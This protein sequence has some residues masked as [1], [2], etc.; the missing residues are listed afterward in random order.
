MY[1]KSVAIVAIDNEF[2]HLPLN[3]RLDQNQLGDRRETGTAAVFLDRDGVVVED[4]HFIK[5][6]SEVRLLP[7]AA[8]ALARLRSKFFII[9]VTNQS[10]VAR[11]YFSETDLAEIHME[12]VDQLGGRGDAI[13][14]FY[15]CPHLPGAQITDYDVECACRK[16]A[17]GM[18][19]QAE[20]HW[21][22]D[23]SQ[24]Y[25]I[26]D[27]RR[28]IDAGLAAGMQSYYV[29]A[30]PHDLPESVVAAPDLLAAAGLIV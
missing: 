18:L 20:A 26:G 25:M 27:S 5:R 6:P 15:Y 29:G 28:D 19:E 7:G 16:P 13:D 10:G 24:S 3:G 2:L 1:S 17:P 23:L 11:G 21:G 30:D 8:E 4:I 14:A 22:F 9:I 12:I